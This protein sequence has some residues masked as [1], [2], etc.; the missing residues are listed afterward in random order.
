MVLG[1]SQ[2]DIQPFLYLA[3]R[4]V[5]HGLSVR[6]CTHP[7]YEKPVEASGSEFFALATGDPR[8]ILRDDYDNRE[9]LGR[10]AV[11]KR[12]LTAAEPTTEHLEKMVSA[13]GGSNALLCNAVVGYATHIGEKLKIPT[14]IV[15]FAPFYPTRAFP[16]PVGPQNLALPGPANLLS[17]LLLQK[18]NWLANASWINRW[19][20][21][22]LGLPAL[23]RW[24]PQADALFQRFFAFSPS[25]LPSIEDWPENNRITGFWFGQSS[26]FAPPTDL[27]SFLADKSTIA[28]CFGSVLDERVGAV[29]R[30]VIQA[31]RELG[32]QLIVVG[33]WGLEN[34]EVSPDVMF[35]PFVPYS[36]LFPRVQMVVHAAGCGTTAEVL[37]AGIPS[38]T[39]PFAGE[40]KF[41]AH[42]LWKSG[43][44]AP[45][46]DRKTLTQD[47][48]LKTLRTVRD[49]HAMR[50]AAASLGLRVQAEDGVQRTIELLEKDL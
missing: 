24:Q 49:N 30:H 46:L 12:L 10:A 9:R 8:Q 32:F 45:P 20:V 42:R 35:R 25:L 27:E 13:C 6:L 50:Q 44:S 43:A 38:A 23:H 31:G 7:M 47:A 40:Q 37:R 28:I 21:R 3:E 22:N 36:W 19:R 4:L 5:E 16:P 48:V 41:W 29:V 26:P 15:H 2:G 11:F 33:G 14:G 18:M 34:L 39:V 1:G 17:H